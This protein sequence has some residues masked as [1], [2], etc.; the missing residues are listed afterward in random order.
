MDTLH[1]NHTRPFLAKEPREGGKE[2]QD[3]RSA[4]IST[5][6]PTVSTVH[7]E[8]QRTLNQKMTGTKVA[9]PPAENL[10]PP[11]AEQGKDEHQ[12]A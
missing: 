5:S 10:T 4:A 2:S 7:T 1:T 12:L 9:R 11:Q 3:P 8:A 6:V